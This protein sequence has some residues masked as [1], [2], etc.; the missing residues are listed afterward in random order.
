[1]GCDGHLI[2]CFNKQAAVD[3]QESR[4]D[5]LQRAKKLLRS[6]KKIEPELRQILDKK[7]EINEQ[8]LNVERRWDGMSF[9]FTTGPLSV[10]QAIKAYF[11]KDVVE[12]CFQELKG[13]VR[14]RPVRQWL[15]R[16][17]EAHVF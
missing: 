12:K 16:H 14:L 3:K 13:V 17:V 2:A 1:G 4:L 7:S 9:I 15:S 11:D 8:R 6:R 10:D 5:K